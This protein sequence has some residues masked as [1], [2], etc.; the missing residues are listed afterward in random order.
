MKA[1]QAA[2]PAGGKLHTQ[3]SRVKP[4]HGGLH[5]E[6]SAPFSVFMRFVGFKRFVVMR[7]IVSIES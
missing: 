2:K 3:P 4:N 1:L 6:G 7:G 5:G